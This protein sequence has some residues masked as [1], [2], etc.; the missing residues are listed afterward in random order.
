MLFNMF[1]SQSDPALNLSPEDVKTKLD[2]GEKIILL[3]VREPWEVAINRLN[4]AV[5]IPLGEL[6]QRYTELNPDA[7]IVVYCHM[8]VRSLKATRFL[9]DR[10]FK[11][12]KNLAGGIEAWSLKVDPKVPRYR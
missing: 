12:V 2:R 4:D 3:D 5:V 11:N 7:E 10:Q 9:I 1:Q 6:G 8:G